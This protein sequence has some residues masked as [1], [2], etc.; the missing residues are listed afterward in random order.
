MQFRQGSI[1]CKPSTWPLPAAA[2]LEQ[3]P[4]RR[5]LC[6]GKL[7]CV[8]AHPSILILPL[9]V[10]RLEWP[11]RQSSRLTHYRNL[12]PEYVSQVH[13]VPRLSASSKN[14]SRAECKARADTA[15]PCHLAVG[16]FVLPQGCA[17]L[18][19]SVPGPR[20]PPW[21]SDGLVLFRRGRGGLSNP[22][23]NLPQPSVIITPKDRACLS[24]RGL[25]PFAQGHGFFTNH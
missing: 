7:P 13:Q 1:I 4:P 19:G 15:S 21:G 25:P 18:V 8:Q 14:T 24:A 17:S 10:G 12:K 3:R 11:G 16:R 20:S 22:S 23:R 5:P 9:A 2:S 6:T